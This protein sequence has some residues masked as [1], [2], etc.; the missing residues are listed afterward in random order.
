MDSFTGEIYFSGDYKMEIIRLESKNNEAFRKIC[1]WYYE[2]I[3]MTKGQSREL[4]EATMSHSLCTGTR[5]PQTFVAMMDN[6]P[7]GMY[8]IAVAD[9]LE[10]RPDIYPWLI[11]V[12]VDKS[13]RGRGVFRAMMQ[14][15]E[16]NARKIGLK[17]LYLYTKHVGLYEKFGWEFV[18]HVDTF[19][20]DSRIERLYRLTVS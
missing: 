18:E 2:W 16:D 4:I 12:Y 11:N 7:A 3:G 8:Q 5:M 14:T 20:E 6:K 19:R 15:V 13:C 1:D 17:E 10:S 9:D